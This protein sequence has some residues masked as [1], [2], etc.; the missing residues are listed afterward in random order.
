MS[1]SYLPAE[2]IA[3]RKAWSRDC[4][5]C[6]TSFGWSYNGDKAIY[7]SQ[8]CGGRAV[9]RIGAGIYKA[10]RRYVCAFCGASFSNY[11]DNRK[12]CSRRCSGSARVGKWFPH[13]GPAPPG[14]DANQQEIV[15]A[16]R[17]AGVVVAETHAVGGG[18]PDLICA[19]NGVVFL[20][21]VKNP[22]T[23]HG[24]KGLSRRQSEFFDQWNGAL[25]AVVTDSVGALRFAR[26]AGNRS[27]VV[28]TSEHER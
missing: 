26:Q 19:A 15:S 24:K 22:A 10:L 13:L 18:F 7:C 2:E 9:G 6:G 8:K 20:L 25:M 21:E 4:A 5:M 1:G 11:Y 28:A 3:R 17:N 23:A 27:A 16:L 14:C 12:Y